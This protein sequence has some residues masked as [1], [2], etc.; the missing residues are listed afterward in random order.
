MHDSAPLDRRGL[1]A[2]LF[3]YA[4]WG[5]F[6]L[7][8]YLLKAVPALQII[9]HRV[10]WCALF[11][12]LVLAW[13]DGVGW[14]RLA[15]QQRRALRWLL[16]SSAL[17][18]FNWGVYIWAVT[19]GRVVEASLG[20][21]INPLVSVA[22]GVLVLR[23]RLNPAQWSAVALAAAGVL[24]LAWRVGEPPWIA[25]ALAGSFA[26]YGL[27][28]RLVKVEALPGLAI[29][30]LIMLAPAL[31]YLGWSELKGVAMFAA[32][33][34]WV[35]I[36]LVLGGV[37]TALPLAAFAYG[38]RRIP[39]SLVGLLQYISPTLQLLC[40]L[41]LLGER[42]LPAQLVGFLCIWAGLALYAGDGWR[43]SRR[44]LPAALVEPVR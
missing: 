16:L 42:L 33:G 9:A 20:Y 34:G 5:V 26:C 3:A 31:A 40:G 10:L 2:A 15:W 4:L 36:L 32:A 28:R 37:L 17:I 22:I 1:W 12:V 8:W 6:P 11:V 27:I 7:Y 24:W 19:H 14:L 38:A 44:P 29:E 35:A 30:S 13:R 41:T 18:S 21:F 43:R 25:L 23:E 39:F